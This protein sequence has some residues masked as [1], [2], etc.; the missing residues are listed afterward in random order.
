MYLVV[1]RVTPAVQMS[2]V[3]SETEHISSYTVDLEDYNF[4]VILEFRLRHLILQIIALRA[5]TVSQ[6]PIPLYTL[7][8]ETVY[9][10]W[11]FYNHDLASGPYKI[12]QMPKI[13]FG[14][15][16]EGDAN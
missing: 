1:A 14:F 5:R 8:W 4:K 2:P 13:S 16:A 12:T 7:F 10:N 6:F 11:L 15:E 9:S 3:I